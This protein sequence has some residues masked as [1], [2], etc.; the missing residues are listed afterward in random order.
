MM[1]NG[2]AGTTSRPRILVVDDEPNIRTAL[3]RL[4]RL[5]GFDAGEAAS[6][7]D[8]LATL[9]N[10]AYE[11]MIVD[12][13]LPGM[14]GTEVMRQARL[15][16]P[17]LRM[18]VLTGHPSLDSAIA[19]IRLEAVDYLQKPA[20]LTEIARVA[21]RALQ[22]RAEELRRRQLLQVI[23][24]AVDVLRKNEAPELAGASE[25][26]TGDPK[27]PHVTLES[28]RRQLILPGNP[29]RVVE[30]TEGEM[31][32]LEVLMSQPDQVFSCRQIVQLA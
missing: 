22:S 2:S 1:P 7:P 30:L 4:F 14:D 31:A 20:S 10:K 11:L 32:V 24:E 21:E 16:D 28:D 23:G 9:R 27:V 5:K 26:S 19:A 15:L 3:T 29:E 25:P 13:N 18:I 17:D 12:L 8:A 6:G